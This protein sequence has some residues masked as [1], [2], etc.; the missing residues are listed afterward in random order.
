M[1]NFF[2]ISFAPVL[3]TSSGDIIRDFFN[4]ALAASVRYDRCVG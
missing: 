4:P 2:D 3:D 1:S